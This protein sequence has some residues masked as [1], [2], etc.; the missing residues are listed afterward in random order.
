[1]SQADEE[2]ICAL[3]VPRAM[4]PVMTQVRSTLLGSSMMVVRERKLLDTYLARLPGEHH[5]TMLTLAAGTWLPIAL[6]L[7][8]YRVMDSLDLTADEQFAI[9]RDVTVKLHQ[10]VV[11]TFVRLATSSGAT[12]FT[13]LAHFDRL[14]ARL[15]MG[16]SG[17]VYKTGPKEARIECI[18][19][20]LAHIRYFRNA[21][22]G[23]IAGSCG[24]F[25]TKIYVTDLPKLTAPSLVAFRAAWA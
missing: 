5:E 17:V 1:M 3:T 23:L 18:Q 6:A 15:M 7:D 10:S 20:P 13:V 21:W 8:H 24:M 11:G 14:W 16:G 25:C 4:V 12:P 2:A 22:R 9:G 19:C